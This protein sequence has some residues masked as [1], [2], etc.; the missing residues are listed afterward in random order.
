MSL[1]NRLWNNGYAALHLPCQHDL[2]RRCLNTFR[3][4]LNDRIFQYRFLPFVRLWPQWWIGR[5]FN[6]VLM[7][8]IYQIVLLQQGMILNLVDRRNNLGFFNQIAQ[9]L[10]RKIR[11]ADTFDGA[12]PLKFLHCG[13]CN[14]QG[15]IAQRD[16]VF[17][18]LGNTGA[19]FL[20][21]RPV[22]QKQIQIIQLQIF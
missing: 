21:Y 3:N 10:G 5:N 4:F 12:F 13:P 8:K 11:N 7:A 1:M 16:Q 17:R 20:R 6:I 2:S 14:L 15:Q 18:T 19:F 22:H 9:F